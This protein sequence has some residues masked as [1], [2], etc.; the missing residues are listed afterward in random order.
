MV[1]GV[2]GSPN[3]KDSPEH[4][5]SINSGPKIRRFCHVYHLR[6]LNHA[7][8]PVVRPSY[9]AFR[10]VSL[11][12]FT[13]REGMETSADV[14]SVIHT[15]FQPQQKSMDSHRGLSL[16]DARRSC[17]VM[18]DW[19]LISPV[20][21]SSRK[22]QECCGKCSA[23]HVPEVPAVLLALSAEHGKWRASPIP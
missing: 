2:F 7:Q 10:C 22:D 21:P 17:F 4:Q 15:K 16:L 19:V 3:S 9:L 13:S 12:V 18:T 8:Y 11:C 20:S 5:S 23:A 14:L 1:S 6:E